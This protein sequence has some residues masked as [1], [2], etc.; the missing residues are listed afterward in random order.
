MAEYYVHFESCLSNNLKT[1]CQVKIFI[2]KVKCFE[3]AFVSLNIGS[4]L[5]LNRLANNQSMI[6]FR[7]ILR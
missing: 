6:I 4:L 2:D 7:G 5:C 3:N 1:S